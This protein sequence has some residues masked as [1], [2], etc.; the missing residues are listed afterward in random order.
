MIYFFRLSRRLW[1]VLCRTP[2]WLQTWTSVRPSLKKPSPDYQLYKNHI[3]ISNL[4]FLSKCCEKV[5]ASQF[6]S[7]LRENKL[8]EIIKWAIAL[9]QHCWECITMCYVHWM[10]EGVWC[11][12][13]WTCRQRSAQW[14]M[15]SYSYYRVSPSALVLRALPTLGLK[16]PTHKLKLIGS[17]AV[18]VCAPYLWNSLPC[19][20]KSSASV[21]I[22]KAKLKTYLFRQAYF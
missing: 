14:I 22:F 13:C 1:T 2:R 7:H 11:W 8:E 4:M 9:N 17:R 16:Q 20:I 18:S 21:S 19:E 5:V 15:A 12:Y 10:M 3:P 6:I